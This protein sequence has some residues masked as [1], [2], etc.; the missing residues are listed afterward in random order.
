MKVTAIILAAGNGSRM[1][2]NIKKQYILLAGKPILWHTINAFENSAVDDIVL[3]TGKDDIELCEEIVQ[4]SHFKKVSKI[5]TGGDERYESVYN[6]LK[7]VIDTDIVLIHDGARPFVTEEIISR[8]II[9]AQSDGACVTGVSVKDTIKIAD[10]DNN[11]HHTPD[12]NT[13]W[14]VQTPQSFVYDL[15][16]NAYDKMFDTGVFDVTDDAMVVEKYTD[17]KVRIIQGD[18]SNI[19]ITTP[20]DLIVG[21]N[22]LK[23]F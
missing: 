17:H 22:F 12:R 18:Y 15:I 14:S 9:A 4:A 8:N 3:V 7:C 19:K 13:V 20:D 5:V 11:V 2:S 6:G 1:K 10:E 23:N 16:K 21:E